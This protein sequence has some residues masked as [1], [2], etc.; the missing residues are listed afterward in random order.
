M[1]L[2]KSRSLSGKMINVRRSNDRR[3]AGPITT[4]I[5]VT[6]VVDQNKNDVRLVRLRSIRNARAHANQRAHHNAVIRRF[7]IGQGVSVNTGDTAETKLSP[8]GNATRNPKCPMA[9]RGGASAR[10]A[11][12][13]FHAISTPLPPR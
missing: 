10:L 9:K 7:M 6:H 13:L 8:A 2:R 1:I 5:R 12:R 11:T 4:R 3:A